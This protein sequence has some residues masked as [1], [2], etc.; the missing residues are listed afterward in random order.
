MSP[1]PPLV[2]LLTAVYIVLLGALLVR[3][4]VDRLHRR[5]RF[6][7]GFLAV[8]ACLTSILLLIPYNT[9]PY[10]RAWVIHEIAVVALYFLI[11][12]EM[13]GLILRD[14]PGIAGLF[15]WLMRI[16]VPA[17]ILIS[18]LPAVFAFRT[19]LQS[20]Y[21]VLSVVM[22]AESTAVLSVLVFLLVVEAILFWFPL[23][24]SRNVVVYCVGYLVFFTAQAAWLSLVGQLRIAVTGRANVFMQAVS[25]AC[26]LFWIAGLSGRGEER[27][28]VVGASWRPGERER[29]RDQLRGMNELLFRVF[30]ARRN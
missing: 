10:F 3:L 20:P 6:F 25:C 24:L 22:T 27:E 11:V 17:A 8:D 18:L 15:R 5:Y 14:Y 7:A 16:S 12:L 1:L 26:L 29:M 4:V 30:R 13:Y 2:R 21:P 9:T 23:S 19:L 28:M